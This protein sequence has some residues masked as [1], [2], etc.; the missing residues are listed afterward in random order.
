[1]K[2]YHQDGSFKHQVEMQLFSKFKEMVEKVQSH[3]KF[4]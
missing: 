4:A 1:M 2:M 3:L